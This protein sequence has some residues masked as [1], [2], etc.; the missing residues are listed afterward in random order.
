MEKRG[1]STNAY[2]H[3]GATAFLKVGSREIILLGKWKADM[4]T[5]ISI[6]RVE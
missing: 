2:L 1:K 5:N 3:S 4:T 6:S